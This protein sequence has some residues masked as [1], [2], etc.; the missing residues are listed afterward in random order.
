MSSNP[1]EP[2]KDASPAVG[3]LSGA[4][5]DVLSVARFQKGVLVCVLVYLVSI[6]G[7]LLL[8]PDVGMFLAVVVLFVAVVGA[9]FVFLL[10]LKLFGTGL[11]ILFGIFTLVPIVGVFVLMGI[12]GKATRVLRANGIKVGLLGAKLSEF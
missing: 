11:G 6:L 12:N 4:H 2:P 7:Q 5:S 10:S 8:P 3:V 9:V 1:Y